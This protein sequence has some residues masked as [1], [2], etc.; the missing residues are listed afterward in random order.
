MMPPL[1]SPQREMVEQNLALVPYVIN[2]MNLRGGIGGNTYQDLVQIGSLGLIKAVQKYNP[3]RGA[4]S[5]IAVIEIHHELYQLLRGR[6]SDKR[7]ANTCAL[8]LDAPVNGDKEIS[9]A[10]LLPDKKRPLDDA[11]L[12]HLLCEKVI[13]YALESESVTQLLVLARQI[14]QREAAR[15]LCCS[16]PQV[17]RKATSFRLNAVNVLNG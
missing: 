6:K 4:F 13:N 1:T 3:S 8:P 17:S 10:A 5:T 9:Y 15:R 14:P 11:V 12:D 16:Q 2:K 7:K